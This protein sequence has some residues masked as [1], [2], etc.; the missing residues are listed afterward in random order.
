MNWSMKK[1]FLCQD[2]FIA[3]VS[4]AVISIGLVVFAITA[5]VGFH[6]F[7]F[8]DETEKFVAAQMIHQGHHLYRDIF[9]HHG[10]VPYMLAHLYTLLVSPNNFT[11]IR[12]FPAL[13]AVLSAAAIYLSPV[14]KTTAPR[15][16]SAGAYFL[17]LSPIWVL[18]GIH[19]LLYQQ[20]GGFLLTIAFMQ[21]SFPLFFGIKPTKY[22]LLVSGIAITLS[23]FTSYAFGASALLL[24][25]ASV[26]LVFASTEKDDAKTLIPPFLAGVLGG[27]LAIISWMLLFAD[28]KGFLV[29]HF[30]FNQNVYSS[31]VVISLKKLFEIFYFSL[32]QDSI[33]HSFTLLLF[34][35]WVCFFVFSSVDRSST[36]KTL[37][38]L[39]AL[40]LLIAS[41]VLLNLRAIT[42]FQD[43]GFVVANLAAFAFACGLA[44][45][46]HL[47]RGRCLW[48]IGTLSVFAFSVILMKQIGGYAVS[49]FGLVKKADFKNHLD[50]MKPN[51]YEVFEFIRAITKKEDDLL[52][53]VFNPAMYIR[54]DRLPASGNYYYLPWQAAY[55]KQP[56]DGY[57]IDICDD[58][59]K[60]A[61]SVIAF[62]N[63]KVW[64]MYPIDEYEPCVPSLINES[65]IHLV[66]LGPWYVRKD[67]FITENPL[68]NGPTKLQPSAQLGPSSTISLSMTPSHESHDV[69][70]KRIGVMLGSYVKRNSGKAELRL[71]GPGGS[72]F[73]QRFDLS[74]VFD[75]KY[76]Y[77][78]IDSKRYTTGELIPV[79]GGGITAWESH[80]DSRGAY[81]CIIYVYA[82]GKFRTTPGCPLH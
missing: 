1:S 40:L 7:E 73:S 3:Y 81:T 4:L 69:G 2:K 58:I 56:I 63:W 74:S 34:V 39:F 10:P 76:R 61:P 36:R 13:L 50:L 46:H 52:V 54:L 57:K 80:N 31:F 28:F 32:S 41:I 17:L 44:M 26:A 78:D 30:Y 68:E 35:F 15:A 16:L 75:K 25:A 42:N 27:A 43:S 23:C 62:D 45:Q 24:L 53:L 72:K 37:A 55:N 60:N 70:L 21:L 9:A 65:Y 38:R 48:A 82:D 33:I 29:Y 18:Q 49:P 79:S 51:R 6:I 11:Y 12:V 5:R 14:F 71:R 19:M 20:I 59:E 8:G 64:D 66:D 77:F 22:G 47:Q 67:I